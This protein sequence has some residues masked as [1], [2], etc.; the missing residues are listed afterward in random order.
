LD[1]VPRS[2]NRRF[3]DDCSV[4][5]SQPV[6][7][8]TGITKTVGSPWVVPTYDAAERSKGSKGS[9]GKEKIKAE[10]TRGQDS[11]RKQGA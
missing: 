11:L 10:K 8:I 4:A 1:G 3:V 7:E 9:K 2:S 6:N 5:F